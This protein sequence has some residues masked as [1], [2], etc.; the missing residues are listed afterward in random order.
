MIDYIVNNRQTATAKIG[1]QHDI[2]IDLEL[3][4]S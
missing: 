4:D 2:F 1:L 3:F